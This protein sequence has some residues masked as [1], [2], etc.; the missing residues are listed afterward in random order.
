M[1]GLKLIFLS[2][3]LANKFCENYGVFFD[4]KVKFNEF[5]WNIM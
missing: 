3:L 1:P 4:M 5:I 2:D